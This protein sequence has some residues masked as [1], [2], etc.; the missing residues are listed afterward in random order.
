MDHRRWTTIWFRKYRRRK[1][2]LYKIPQKGLWTFGGRGISN[3]CNKYN[4][5]YKRS[6]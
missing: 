1:L 2:E 5:N 4:N 6:T 3:E